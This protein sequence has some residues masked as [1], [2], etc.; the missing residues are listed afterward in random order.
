MADEAETP[1]QAQSPSG[2]EK[3]SSAGRKG[4]GGPITLIIVA[5]VLLLLAA[6]A[7][8]ANRQLLETD[9]W[10]ETST[11]LLA[12]EEVQSALAVVLVDALYENVDVEAQVREALPPEIQG[13]AGPVSGG[14]RELA[15]QAA[16]EV[17]ASAPVQTL[18]E[19]ANRT[20]HEAF[21]TVIEGGDE[22]VTT[23]EGTV[24]L[25]LA[26]IAEQVGNRVGIDVAGQL[27][28]DA[29]QIEI[30]QSDELSAVQTGADILTTVAWILVVVA[31]GLFGLAIYLART[32]RREA[33][34]ATAW[35]FIIVGALILILRAVAG[36]AIVNALAATDA[37]TPAVDSVWSIGTSALEAVGV[38][39]ITYGVIGVIG[40]WLAGRT[41]SATATR[42]NLAPAFQERWVAYA[43][44]A[45]VVILLFLL[46]PAEG[47]TRLIPSLILIALM[48]AGF[49]FLRR[50]T[51]LEFPNARWEDVTSRWQERLS[52]LGGGKKADEADSEG[53]LAELERLGRLR[54]AGTLTDEEFEREKRRLI[55][56]G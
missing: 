28:P 7:V 20:A 38:S 15:T 39:L 9:T 17:L 1:G 44:L 54:E 25:N 49:E 53:R 24:T 56:T 5:S 33:I 11:D 43:I 29:A 51:V 26:P 55:D 37:D 12:D 41:A 8:W 50:Q 22:A 27:P 14:I 21:V 45:V 52:S 35:A 13:L 34:R 40:V 30:L 18:W 2:E 10:V 36:N 31:L 46:A 23:E 16:R 6:F 3:D 32:W 42:R 4:R 47:T 48:I 19:E